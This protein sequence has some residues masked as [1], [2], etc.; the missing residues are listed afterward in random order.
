MLHFIDFLGFNGLYI[1]ILLLLILFFI[2]IFFG[3][4][5]NKRLMK[6]PLLAFY[7]GFPFY[8]IAL[9]M[10]L[11]I[12]LEYGITKE[13]NEFLE[14]NKGNIELQIN[15]DTVENNEEILKLFYEGGDFTNHSSHSHD[16]DSILV[17][18]SNGRRNKKIVIRRDVIHPEI[19]LYDSDYKT[20]KGYFGRLKTTAFDKYF[21]SINNPY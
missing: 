5:I 3:K 18:F 17:I 4:K 1:F 7:F 6:K 12:L 8:F 11:L 20:N 9:I 13:F 14:D 21:K 16:S 19:W 15:G 2:F 10:L